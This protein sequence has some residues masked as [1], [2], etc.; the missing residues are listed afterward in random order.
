MISLKE[1]QVIIKSNA[2]G[3]RIDSS[4]IIYKIQNEL[5]FGTKLD[6]YD[7]FFK[8]FWLNKVFSWL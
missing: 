2:T 6:S 8:V 1:L 3:E 5:S 4:D 7:F